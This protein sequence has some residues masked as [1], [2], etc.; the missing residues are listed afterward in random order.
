M[1]GKNSIDKLQTKLNNQEKLLD[2]KQFIINELNTQLAQKNNDS[3]K[4]TTADVNAKLQAQLK[5]IEEQKKLINQQEDTIKLLRAELNKKNEEVGTLGDFLRTRDSIIKHYEEIIHN[6]FDNSLDANQPVV[7]NEKTNENVNDNNAPVVLKPALQGIFDQVKELAKD[8]NSA[9]QPK[10]LVI[11]GVNYGKCIQGTINQFNVEAT[12]ACTCFGLEMGL[13]LLLDIPLSANL[14]DFVIRLGG[15]YNSAFHATSDEIS[16]TARYA[17]CLT[18]TKNGIFNDGE[19]LSTK[20]NFRNKIKE[21]ALYAQNANLAIRVTNP[22]ESFFLFFTKTKYILFDS[23]S[24]RHLGLPNA[25]FIISDNID[26]LLNYLAKDLMADA[27]EDG[28]HINQFQ[29]CA[30]K[31]ISYSCFKLKDEIDK[32]NLKQTL[33]S[34]NEIKK[35]L[36]ALR[37]VANNAQQERNAELGV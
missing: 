25:H 31:Y 26:S 1:Y 32:E 36:N 15:A 12:G 22:P 7:A 27:G 21:I 20:A 34:D 13:L 28:H 33:L 5:Q 6:N 4:P 24:R 8:L 9:T 29:A 3:N 16:P 17:S 10:D 37:D 35:V 30:N 2:Q 18:K 23:H 19:F 11:K 14:I